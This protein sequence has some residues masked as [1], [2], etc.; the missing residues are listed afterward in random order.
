VREYSQFE[1]LNPVREYSQSESDEGILTSEFGE[2][3]LTI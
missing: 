3:I 1:N 2:G